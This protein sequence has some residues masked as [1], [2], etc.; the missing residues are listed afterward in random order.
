MW[1]Q[2]ILTLATCIY[3]SAQEVLTQTVIHHGQTA[4]IHN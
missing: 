2:T 4:A 3:V 1:G